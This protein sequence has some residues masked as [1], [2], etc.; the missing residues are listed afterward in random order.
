[1]THLEPKAA[2]KDGDIG[3]DD[4]HRALAKIQDSIDGYVKQ[5]DEIVTEKEKENSFIPLNDDD[6][7]IT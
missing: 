3:E 5:V 1:M 6:T 2:Q 7:Y 4:M